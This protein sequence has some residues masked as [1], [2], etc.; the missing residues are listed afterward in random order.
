MASFGN[1]TD[2]YFGGD[3]ESGI[4]LSGQVV[5]RIDAIRPVAEIIHSCAAGCE[6]TL[7]RLSAR[8]VTG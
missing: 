3:L 8:Y 6:E 7:A 5:G 4:P 2:L 1:V